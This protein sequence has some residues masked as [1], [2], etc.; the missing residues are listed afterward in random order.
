MKKLLGIALLASAMAFAQEHGS[1]AAPSGVAPE[2][3]GDATGHAQAPVEPSASAGQEHAQVATK[4]GEGHEEEPMPNEIWWKWANFALLA[5]GLGYL[6][7]KNAGPFFRSRTEQIQQGIRDAAQVRADA[8]AR[9]AEI[10]ARVANLSAEV[11]LLRRRSKEEIAT[12]GARVQAET[13][14]QIAKVQSRAEAEIA[15][16]GKHASL[17]LKAYSAQLALDLAEK[18]SRQ[19]LDGQTQSDLAGMFIDDLRQEAPSAVGGVQ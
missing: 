8:E 12:E 4:H 10:E 7:G 3:T 19:R 5:G 17:E 13:T 9:A 14:A 18:Q 6:I 15:S 1:A 16:A 2:S 11:E